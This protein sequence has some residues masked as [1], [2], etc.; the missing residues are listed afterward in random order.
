[1]QHAVERALKSLLNGYTLLLQ[2]MC[3][4]PTKILHVASG[5]LW[6]GAEVMLYNLVSA[7]RAAAGSTVS[8]IV[9]NRGELAATLHAA[10]VRT[11]VLPE[12]EMSV[13]KLVARCRAIV[14]E[15]DPEVVHSHRM[16]EDVIVAAATA[17]RN[18]CRVRTVH[19]IDE[20]AKHSMTLRQH[21]IRLIH[22]F[23][24]TQAFHMSFAVARSLQVSLSS[25]YKKHLVSYIPNG[26]DVSKLEFVSP[27]TRNDP[28]VIG[29]AGRLV[30]I[31]RVD[32]FL[33][34]AEY[35]QKKH[36]NMYRFSIFGDGPE[37]DSLRKLS[38][39]LGLDEVVTYHGF[40]KDMQS[41]LRSV[42]LLYLTSD[43]EGLPMI[44]LEAMACGVPIVSP[45]VGEI[46]ELL[47]NGE[48][49][50]LVRS[51]EPRAYAS[52]ALDYAD[53]QS[54]FLNKAA[55]ARERV[56]TIYSSRATARRYLDAYL[57][58]L[59]QKRVTE[60]SAR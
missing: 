29:F 10:G 3:A 40:I 1:M 12:G 6:A 58:L 36:P 53:D 16:K 20:T 27:R 26:V 42:D 33:R 37:L 17:D 34:M 59:Q 52:A 47:S 11:Y 2:M 41:R 48:C 14:A 18:V 45:A 23:C 31:K 24:V 21:A 56:T 39:A 60:R 38:G 46:P 4:S 15:I 44:L 7:Q 51:Q 19:G 54:S 49:G 8:V 25:R 57:E 32:L 30:A 28:I 50:I 9:L 22:S 55:R 43:S 5:D 13:P 35:L